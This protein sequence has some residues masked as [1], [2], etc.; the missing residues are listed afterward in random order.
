MAGSVLDVFSLIGELSGDSIYAERLRIRADE[1]LV[2]SHGQKDARLARL[3]LEAEQELLRR[4]KGDLRIEDLRRQAGARLAALGSDFPGFRMLFLADES[5]LLAVASALVREYARDSGRF[6]GAKAVEGI[7]A[8]SL[9]DTPWKDVQVGVE[10]GIPY[11]QS[12]MRSLAECGEIVSAL[13]A[14]WYR[15]MQV[16][17]GTAA[18]T[19]LFEFA[20]RDNEKSLG[21][22]PMINTL[23]SLTPRPVLLEEKAKRLHEL[24]SE[25]MTQARSIRTAD[26]DLSRQ[27]AQLQATVVELQET[28]GRLE[29][30]SNARSEFI[31][32]VAHQFRTPLS[33]IRWNSE[34]LTDALGEKKID[35]QFAD[36]IETMRAKSVF[37]I[38]TLDRVFATL[39]IE[40]GKL[41]ID[42]KP[43]FLWEAVQDAYNQYEKDIA[44]R[45]L[46]WK[47]QRTKEQLKQIPMDKAKIATVLKILIGNAI[48]Y[49]PDGG[50]IAVS[51]GDREINGNDYQ[52]F[53]IKDAGIG[54]PERDTDRVFEK[55]YRAPSAKLKAPDGTGLGM[56]IVKSFI[57]AHR[58]L[59]RLESEGEGKGTT[60]S[61]A[62]PVK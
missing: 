9:Q 18:S 24:E 62:L 25:T 53:T 3:Y 6:F 8:A 54:I 7:V 32:V 60:V 13:F 35:A 1:V 19:R 21:F 55:F 37:L 29:A 30:V 57:E 10:K 52:V 15:S 5:Q 16:M 26:Q 38:E 42:A 20:Y 43:A 27:A 39:D 51:I 41:V 31:D 36:A 14:G 12:R 17:I 45:G 49:S 44:R 48:S 40:T 47:F 34:L 59:I 50:A 4:S 56:F 22:L 58:G 61:F 28:R 33:S 46:K 23:L 11:N 2:S